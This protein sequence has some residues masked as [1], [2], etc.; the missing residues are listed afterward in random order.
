MFHFSR[1]LFSFCLIF[2]IPHHFLPPNQI[3]S[4]YSSIKHSFCFVSTLG[5]SKFPLLVMSFS[6]YGHVR[7]SDLVSLVPPDLL[8]SLYVG[9]LSSAL[10]KRPVVLLRP[11]ISLTLLLSDLS[12]LVFWCIGLSKIFYLKLMSWRRSHPLPS[13]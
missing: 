13:W 1:C 10:R 4:H 11:K 9:L 7:D 2:P 3:L 12:R 5:T 8:S 6:S